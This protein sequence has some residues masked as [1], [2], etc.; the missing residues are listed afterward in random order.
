MAVQT[1]IFNST[2][3]PA[4]AGGGFNNYYAASLGWELVGGDQL[5]APTAERFFEFGPS[6][7]DHRQVW[8]ADG[9]YVVTAR[10]LAHAVWDSPS[11]PAG[12]SLT[13]DS[14]LTLANVFTG[15]GGNF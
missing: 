7:P 14:R 12:R 1:A 5:D 9:F 15:G 8:L 3:V 4:F 6:D 11:R 10:L 2:G 13:V